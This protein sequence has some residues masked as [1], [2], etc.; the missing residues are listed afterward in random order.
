MQHPVGH[1]V[2]R[3]RQ[4]SYLADFWAFLLNPWALAQYAHNMVAAVVTGVVRDGGR[5]RVLRCCRTST[6]TRRGAS[7]A[8]ASSP[9]SSSS[10]LVAFPTGDRQAK[11]VARHQP[12]ALA[13][14]EGRFESGPMARASC[15]SASPTWPSG[16]STTRSSCPASSAF[17]PTARSTPTSPGSTHFPEDTW[18]DNIELLYYAFHVMVGLGTIFIAAR[19][20]SP[21]LLAWR[22]A[23]P[24]SRADAVD[25]DARVSV[26]VH[27]HHGG[28]D[29]R[30]ARA[31]AVARVRP[32][33]HRGRRQSRR[34]TSGTVLFT[35]IG[36]T[37]PLLRARRAVPVPGRPRDRARAR[38]RDRPTPWP[39]HARRR[40]WL[41]SGSASPR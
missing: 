1:A 26:S 40:A 25:A 22:G 15:S 28:M 2:G 10:V 27:R 21:R 18:P 6:S 36:F 12:V 4:R 14:M 29:D 33:A 7:C 32:D 41:S 9:G 30:G 16:G 5:R 31:P 11:L 20:R 38:R 19:W 39:R 24:R 13:A 8:S 37:R 34:C 23:L 3:R 35:L 17:S